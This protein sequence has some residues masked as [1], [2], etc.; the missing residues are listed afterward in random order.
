MS[1][2]IV[3]DDQHDCAA[4]EECGCG[5]LSSTEFRVNLLAAPCKTCEARVAARF[6]KLGYDTAVK[7]EAAFL[8]LITRSATPLTEAIEETS[9]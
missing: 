2:V 1:D 4:C 6:E 5:R 7:D 9:A 3:V 8:E